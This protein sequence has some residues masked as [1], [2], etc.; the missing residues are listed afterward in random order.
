MA[1]TN[2]SFV[3]YRSFY[4]AL[5][6][7]DDASALRLYHGICAYAL[8]GEL[9][10]LDGITSVAFTLIRPQ[11]DA[12]AKR[13][14]DGKKG[15]RPKTSGY[16]NKKPVVSEM[17]TSGYTDGK[18]NVNANSNDNININDEC[19][20]SNVNNSVNSNSN[21]VNKQI[22]T[23]DNYRPP[24]YYLPEEDTNTELPFDCGW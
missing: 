3:F 21:D 19:N 1:S 12:N 16:K 5:L 7:L 15:G 18:P 9:P 11:L 10:D 14:E 17:K 6:G 22:T 13:R 24:C 2:D 23:D 4:E 20:N 8:D